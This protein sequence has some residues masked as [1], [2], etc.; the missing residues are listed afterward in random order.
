[1][2]HLQIS[3]FKITLRWS[4]TDQVTP[5]CSQVQPCTARYSQVLPSTTR[6]SQVQS[7]TIMYS[8]VHPGA[9]RCNQVQPCTAKYS[10]VQGLWYPLCY[11][12]PWSR[13][14]EFL[15]MTKSNC[16]HMTEFLPMSEFL[17]RAEFLYWAKIV[18]PAYTS[19]S[20]ETLHF[21]GH[22]PHVVPVTYMR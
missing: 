17:S 2:P 14:N 9:A 20:F 1:M 4:V 15:H 8:H 13:F 16:L 3:A 19:S 12:H 21:I 11:M 6:Y 5:R 22:A 7:D 10:Q 18:W